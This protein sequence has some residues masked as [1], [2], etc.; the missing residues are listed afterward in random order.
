V[1]QQNAAP[2][3]AHPDEPHTDGL[4][5]RLNWLRAGVLGANDGIV[6][7][8]GLV[9]GVAGATTDRGPIFV[10]GLAGLVAGAVSMALGEYVSVSS[11]R[12]TELAMMAKEKR[13]LHEGPQAELAELAALYRARGLSAE[14][15]D[16]VA[17]ELTAHD[18]LAAHLE[19]ELNMNAESS[20][21]PGRPPA[22]RPC[23][24]SWAPCCHWSPSCCRRPRGASRSP[25]PPSCSRSG[26][27]ARSAPVSAAP[28]PVEPSSGSSSAAPRALRSPIS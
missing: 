12:D 16:T 24:S 15:A 5:G 28:N 11:Q 6:S 18:P 4:G 26:S 25:W 20:R 19:A 7:V 22:P 13:E 17:R 23:P 9:V 1:R 3:G 27:P 8:A 10:A 21:T 14:T 2:G